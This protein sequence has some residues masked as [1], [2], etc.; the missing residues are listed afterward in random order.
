MSPTPLMALPCP[1]RCYKYESGPALNVSHR[2]FLIILIIKY[3][4][5]SREKIEAQRDKGSMMRW[6]SKI[7]S[8]VSLTRKPFSDSPHLT[9]IYTTCS[10]CLPLTSLFFHP[11]ISMLCIAYNFDLGGWGLEE[12]KVLFPSF[13]FAYLFHF[14]IHKII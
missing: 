2:L 14:P 8:C 13:L 5:Y 4:Y 7:Q 11:S 1:Y 12:E 10:W 3:S 9:F 6:Q